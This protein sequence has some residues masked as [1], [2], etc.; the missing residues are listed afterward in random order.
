MQTESIDFFIAEC[1]EDNAAGKRRQLNKSSIPWLSPPTGK[2]DKEDDKE[3]QSQILDHN[4]VDVDLNR[5]QFEVGK[6]ASNKTG[7][8]SKQ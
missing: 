2:E 8:N 1:L 5:F 4:I 6:S 7:N 3:N